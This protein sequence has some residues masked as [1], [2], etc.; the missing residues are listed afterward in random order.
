[1][2]SSTQMH[3][4]TMRPLGQRLIHSMTISGPIIPLIYIASDKNGNNPLCLLSMVN[5]SPDFPDQIY[6]CARR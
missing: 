4:L 3:S 2:Y 6:M 5:L 1:M